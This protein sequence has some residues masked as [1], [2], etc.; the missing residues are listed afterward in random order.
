M[1]PKAGIEITNLA[2]FRAGLKAAVAG[3]PAQLTAAIRK[4]GQPIVLRAQMLAQAAS[5][6]GAHARGFSVRVSTTT[7][8]LYNREPYGAGAE[9]GLLGHWAGFRR[10]GPRGRFAWR[11]MEESEDA[12]ARIITAELQEL[13]TINGWAR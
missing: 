7:G 8:K 2:L 3:S 6:T 13:L 12:V 4:A 11:A 1:A 9:W 10:Y 5:D